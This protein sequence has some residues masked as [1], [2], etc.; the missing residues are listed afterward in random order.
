MEKNRQTNIEIL[1][2]FSMFLI[3]VMHYIFCGLKQNPALVHYNIGTLLGGGK[4][5]NNGTSVY[6]VP[7]RC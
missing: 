2:V 3:V 5:F 6:I 4:L 1:R 7:D